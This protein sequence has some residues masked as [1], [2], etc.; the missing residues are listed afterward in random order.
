[1]PHKKDSDDDDY[2]PA[3]EKRRL[4][5]KRRAKARKKQSKK[6]KAFQRERHALHQRKHHAKLSDVQRAALNKKVAARN[7]KSRNSKKADAQATTQRLIDSYILRS[8]DQVPTDDMLKRYQQ[9]P[10]MAQCILWLMSG[11]P[12]DY[13]E[14]PTEMTVRP[15][16][17]AM[18]KKWS[19]KMGLKALI[20]VCATCGKRD[21]MTEGEFRLM[22]PDH[23]RLKWCKID[24]KHL[25]E[26]GTPGRD[27]LH[28][29][30]LEGE[31]YHVAAEGVQDGQFIVCN[32]CSTRLQHA[33][34]KGRAPVGTIAHYDLGKIPSHL[35]QLTLAEKLA[36]AKTL[37]FVP[38]IQ[39]KAV[40]GARNVGIKGHAFSVP[41]SKP[42]TVE[43]LPRSDLKEHIQL[44]IYG[45]KET[46]KI[47]KAVARRGPLTLR[48]DVILGWLRW[49]KSIGNPYYKDV[50]IPE[51]DDEIQQCQNMLQ[52][53]TDAILKEASES[54]S[55]TVDRLAS[56]NRRTDLQ[57]EEGLDEKFA[58]DGVIVE[59]VFLDNDSFNQKPM[60]AAVSELN[61]KFDENSRASAKKRQ[62]YAVRIGTGLLNEYERNY[63]I[64]SCGFPNLFPR[65]LTADLFE[66][67]S[68]VPQTLQTSWLLFQDP[69]CARD[70]DLLFFL[71]N[72]RQRHDVNSK[73][74]VKI[75]SADGM[76][77]AFTDLC[78]E[79]DFEARVAAAAANPDSKEAKELEKQISPMIEVVGSQV[80]WSIQERKSALGQMYSMG[81][82]FGVASWFITIS[83]NM[84]HRPLA[85]RL[86]LTNAKDGTEF[87]IPNLFLRSKL[88]TENPVAAAQVIYRLLEQFFKIIVKLPLDDFTGRKA[89][90]H[91][92]LAQNR[93]DIVGAFGRATA[94]YGVLEEQTN[95]NLHYHG[96]IFGGPWDSDVLLRHIHKPEVAK[97]MTDLID[98]MITCK[99]D[100]KFK[101]PAFHQTPNVF[102]AEPCPTAENVLTDSQR[103]S[104]RINHHRHSHTCWK[105][106]KNHCR[107]GFAQSE[108]QDTFFAE[109]VKNPDPNKIGAVEKNGHATISAPPPRTDGNPW[110]HPD[111]RIIVSTLCRRDSFEQYQVEQN[112]IT[113]TCCR[114][115]TSIQ[116]L[117][118]PTQA[119]GATY[120][121]C[122]YCSKNPYELQRLISLLHQATEDNRKYGS[123]AKDAGTAS[124]KSKTIMQK[125]LNRSGIREISNQQAAG[126]ATGKTSF[127][128]SHKYTFVFIWDAVQNHHK[129]QSQ[130]DERIEEDGD[131]VL[132]DVEVDSGTG[133]MV[134]IRQIT[135]YL[136]RSD[137]LRDYC[138]MEWASLIST[139]DIEDKKKKPA[140]PKSG[141]AGRLRNGTFPFD[142]SC[143][144]AKSKTQKLRS[145]PLVPRVT[146]RAPPVYPG[147]RPDSSA[148]KK[149]EA[150][151][152]SKAKTFVEYFSLLLMPLDR[153]GL[154]MTSDGSSILPWNDSTSWEAF[155]REI[156][157]WD[158]PSNGVKTRGWYLRSKWV[159]FKNLVDNLRVSKESQ[160]VMAMWRGRDADSKIEVED[161]V[162]KA[163]KGSNSHSTEEDDDANHCA[164][165]IEAYRQK[166]GTR[167][168]LSAREKDLMKTMAFAQAQVDKFEAVHAGRSRIRPSKTFPSF[169]MEECKKMEKLAGQEEKAVEPVPHNESD[170]E[171]RLQTEKQSDV[172]LREPQKDAISKL[173]RMKSNGKQLFAILHGEPG[174]G[175]TTVAK[176]LV[177]KLGLKVIFSAT[178]NAA[179]ALLRADTINGLLVLGKNLDNFT[180]T[181][182]KASTI[183]TMQENLEDIE[184]LV[185]DEMSM[186][187][188][189]D[190]ARVELHCRLALD[191]SQRFGGLDVLL[192][193][194]HFQFPPIAK[195][196]H[197]AL[198][199][200]AVKL[201]RGSPM[202]NQAYM[203]G[204]IYYTQFKMIEMKGQQRADPIYRVWLNKIRDPNVLQP[205]DDE[206]LSMIPVLSS[207]DLEDPNRDWEFTTTAVS[208]HPE[209]LKI[210][211]FKAEKFGQVYN[212]PILRWVCPV[213]VGKDGRKNVYG[214]LDFDPR[215]KCDPLVRYLVRGAECVLKTKVDNKAGI[216]KATRGTYVGVKWKE[217]D[218]LDIEQLPKGKVTTVPQPEYIVIRVKNQIL[219][220]RP[221]R[222]E[223]KDKLTKRTIVHLAHPCD[224]TFAQTMNILQGATLNSLI[225]SLSAHSRVARGVNRISLPGL[226]VILSRVHSFDE[227]RRLEYSKEDAE[228]LKKLKHDPWLKLYFNNYLPDGTWNQSGLA[229][230]QKNLQMETQIELGMIEL[231]SLTVAESK[232]FAQKLDIIVEKKNAKGY[233]SSLK[234]AHA[235]GVEILS[236]NNQHLFKQQWIKT[237][238]LLRK[239]KIERLS[240]KK[241]RFYAKRLGVKKTLKKTTE[242]LKKI[243]KDLI[244]EENRG[245]K[246]KLS[247]NN[248]APR[249]SKRQRRKSGLQKSADGTAKSDSIMDVM[250]AFSK[251][252]L[253]PKI[254]Q[255]TELK[256]K[257]TISS[258]QKQPLFSESAASAG[259]LAM[260]YAWSDNACWIEACI[261]ILYRAFHSVP[262]VKRVIEENAPNGDL[263]RI[264]CEQF[265]ARETISQPSR[266]REFLKDSK[267]A[268]AKVV[269]RKFRGMGIQAPQVSGLGAPSNFWQKWYDESNQIFVGFEEFIWEHCNVVGT[270]RKRQTPSHNQD[271]QL[272]ND[273][274]VPDVSEFAAYAAAGHRIPVTAQHFQLVV[275]STW[276]TSEVKPRKRA[277]SCHHCN[278]ETTGCSIQYK[279]MR[280]GHPLIYFLE[281]QPAAWLRRRIKVHICYPEQLIF[282]NDN[283]ALWGKIYRHSVHL[284]HFWG[285]CRVSPQRILYFDTIDPAKQQW[286]VDWNKVYEF[287]HENGILVE[288]AIY[289]RV[290]QFT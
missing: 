41:L 7:R 152:C 103:I 186:M 255:K 51:T 200:A 95:G 264:L 184:L 79:D 286:F 62:E 69:R 63:E 236:E 269:W 182:L 129:S 35:L 270:W 204:A 213:K 158:I 256:S 56:N 16:L 241:L 27:V 251:L 211:E 86:A 137:A 53:T 187:T 44:A 64:L 242:P 26:E 217:E 210:L 90:I 121:V 159:F 222:D 278:S 216:S 127:L 115:N 271:L 257:Q 111:P 36:I 50:E 28:L 240:L 165:L 149:E 258:H 223:F 118:A 109:I 128:S 122:K 12:Q 74:S 201:A 96:L 273:E 208:G 173:L 150:I 57:E 289:I 67:S 33:K 275:T 30:E 253:D 214:P 132:L 143:P 18:L 180:Y 139:P 233:I 231:E 13:R 48:I 104:S 185:I 87:E 285:V 3:A 221:I 29:V 144:V 248:S 246:R 225:V 254:Q 55:A 42:D 133:K 20:Q 45:S 34:E 39:F 188:P 102:A 249:P 181:S 283:Y 24:K 61:R 218:E 23:A 198:F 164:M 130:W 277:T 117:V 101:D 138:L 146:G 219:T 145:L 77:E 224:L 22:P 154:P 168:F 235:K 17:A 70:T 290:D 287:E 6:T 82:F 174:S 243:L 49:L 126:A 207:K 215:G 14:A 163:K 68:T 83:P 261:E 21:V 19:T 237:M 206:W 176:Q 134:T 183:R 124:R 147:N 244:E 107:L 279:T 263:S 175:K 10:K 125:L 179:A 94:A 230:F 32:S 161:E 71:Y 73:V 80:A 172:E 60:Q 192:I 136:H 239:E 100:D 205:I 142:P 272:C 120:Y 199:Q 160:T 178:S 72:Q 91:R 59:S 267:M 191:G 238:Q 84:S 190:L 81:H 247:S 226:Y 119:K 135:M 65:G 98:S 52:S 9:D 196:S 4:K 197:P 260:V 166:H 151:W 140:A 202:P 131:D 212:E 89:N 38:V 99:I 195:L 85:L 92:L 153:D 58:E 47:A 54:D 280:L 262:G 157:S 194:D 171:V 245:I 252:K 177:Q 250:P 116:C 11:L 8:A 209:R 66:K 156:R 268:I 232:A 229:A 37:V 1:M 78:N 25:P 105:K 75:K 170:N 167:D 31:F 227:L 46:W 265:Q 193:G 228:A 203:Q 110:M 234:D 108:S 281:E 276:T 148:T 189:V 169:S 274:L 162:K 288:R 141:G 284:G 97:Q 282:L 259:V 106:G 5:S 43:S 93:D 88:I 40:C 76:A 113:T 220:V 112:P 123:V 2:D 114:C 15:D 266:L 155:W